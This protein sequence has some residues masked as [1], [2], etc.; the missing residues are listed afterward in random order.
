MSLSPPAGNGVDISLN[1]DQVAFEEEV[2]KLMETNVTMAM[3]YLQK[4]GLCLMPIALAAAISS[5]KASSSS[6]SVSEEWKKFGFSNGVAQ[7]NSSSSSSNS[8][9]ASE[10]NIIIGKPV[11]EAVLING[12]NGAVK[13]MRNTFCTAAELKPKT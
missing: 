5:G 6:T 3:Q 13:Q 9:L 7:N 2:V 12:C 10:S 8:S 11:R 1:P 4:K